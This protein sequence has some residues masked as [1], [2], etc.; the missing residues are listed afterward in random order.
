MRTPV[1]GVGWS[2]EAEIPTRERCNSGVAEEDKERVM[3]GRLVKTVAKS[4]FEK[5]RKRRGRKSLP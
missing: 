3:R 1:G 2:W 4:T 5:P